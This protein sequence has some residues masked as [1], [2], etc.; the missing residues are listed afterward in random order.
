[1]EESVISRGKK[2]MSSRRA[3]ACMCVL[4]VCV[5]LTSF[6]LFLS[7]TAIYRRWYFFHSFSFFLSFFLSFFETR[8]S[9]NECPT[10]AFF[11]NLSY[12]RVFFLFFLFFLYLIQFLF[13][14]TRYL[15]ALCLLPTWFHA[16]KDNTRDVRVALEREPF[17]TL[18]YYYYFN[19]IFFLSFFLS[20]FSSYK[21]GKSF[22]ERRY[23]HDEDVES[24][25][26]SR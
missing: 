17:S 21:R 18:Y 13:L 23:N 12:I 14:F 3:R 4:C 9:R 2:I 5:N 24:D 1:M 15:C 7:H 6:F 11:L 19:F 8:V 16:Y 10:L 26:W 22:D 20:F 25:L